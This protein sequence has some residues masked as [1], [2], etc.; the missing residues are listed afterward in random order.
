MPVYTHRFEKQLLQLNQ[1]FCCF[2]ICLGECQGL[3]LMH[4]IISRLI[5]LIMYVVKQYV[6]CPFGRG[7]YS[8]VNKYNPVQWRLS[9][10]LE[11][12][13]HAHSSGRIFH[14]KGQAHLFCCL[15]FCIAALPTYKHVGL[16]TVT[17]AGWPMYHNIMCQYTIP[18]Q[19]RIS[20]STSFKYQFISLA[21]ISTV[22]GY[23]NGARKV[24]ASL[25][26][27]NGARRKKS[28]Y[29]L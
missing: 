27:M 9:A 19:L 2:F 8:C 6:Y 18:I 4:F 13:E 5:L 25:A 1:F 12:F 21:P 11:F 7:I 15:Q 29:S 3:I 28:G 10:C 24:D 26:S 23:L 14:I 16:L 20:L 22:A 17:R